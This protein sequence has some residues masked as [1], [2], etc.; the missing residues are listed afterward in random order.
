MNESIYYNVDII[1]SAIDKNV[2]I[3]FQYYQWNV[4][5]EMELRHDGAF[6]QISPWG[7]VWDHENYYM[8]GYD[9]VAGI[10]KH[11]RVDKMIRIGLLTEP[12]KG[13]AQF[14]KMDITAYTKK[15]FSMFDGEVQSVTMICENQ[16][17]GVILDRFGRDVRMR[18]EDDSHFRVT[19]DV[20]VSNNFFG[21]LIG[22]GAGIKLIEPEEVVKQMQDRV[23]ELYREYVEE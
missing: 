1:H 16:F 12:R 8:V 18:K 7:L 20:A 4:D 11:F 19:A 6:Y 5:K 9:S 22:L 2:M 14:Q 13:R 15:R 23:C 3:E 17:A 21:W 10:L